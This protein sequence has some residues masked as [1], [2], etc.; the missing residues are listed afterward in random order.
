M[1]VTDGRVVKDLDDQD[2]KPYGSSMNTYDTVLACSLALL[3]GHILNVD[4]VT[5]RRGS[6]LDWR[7][8]KSGETLMDG[9]TAFDVAYLFVQ[10]VGVGAANL[11][12]T[13]VEAT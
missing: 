4:N 7:H 6:V 3:R 13:Y 11:A 9:G 5:A 2:R 10:E 1:F 8:V 12:V